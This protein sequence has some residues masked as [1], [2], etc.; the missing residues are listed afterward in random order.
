MYN[1]TG[2]QFPYVQTSMVSCI[3]FLDD[4]L[5]DKK[6]NQMM[7]KFCLIIFVK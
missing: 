3:M 2:Q 4:V 1:K 5:K 6:N 7:V